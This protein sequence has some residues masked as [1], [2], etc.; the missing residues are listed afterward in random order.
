MRNY[1][2]LFFRLE[3]RPYWQKISYFFLRINKEKF[4]WQQTRVAMMCR[5]AWTNGVCSAPFLSWKMVVPFFDQPEEAPGACPD[6][7]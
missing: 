6:I 3:K 5:S 4:P 1:R 7:V 2:E